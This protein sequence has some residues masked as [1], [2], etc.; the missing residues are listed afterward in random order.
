MNKTSNNAKSANFIRSVFALVGTIIGVG[1]Y[2]IPYASAQSGFFVGLAY[3]IILGLVTLIILRA[4]GEVVVHTPG[5]G[6]LISFLRKYTNPLVSHMGAVALVG[7]WWGA[8]VAYIII[9]GTFLNQIFS[10]F[11]F[12]SQFFY[13]I[14][15]FA[16]ASA[17]VLGGLGFVSKIESVFVCALLAVFI[18]IFIKATPQI[19]S[20]NLFTADY[21]NMLLPYGVILFAFGGLGAIPEMRDILGQNKKLLLRAIMAGVAISAVVY[22]FFSAVVVGIAGDST[23]K[24]A[25]SSLIPSLG[26][27][28]SVAAPILG[29]FTVIT[30]FLMLSINAVDTFVYDYKIRFLPAWLLTIGVPF[31]AFLLG[32]RDFISVIGFT[33]SILGGALGM[34]VLY[35]HERARKILSRLHLGRL[36][37]P[38]FAVSIAAIVLVF[39]VIGEVVYY[40]ISL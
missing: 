29:F 16:I 37:T 14:V 33:G 15:F 5:H 27:L 1:I 32:A 2:G 22:I 13:Q 38:R 10:N 21:S 3:L 20:E 30:S 6:R 31:L 19:A 7:S 39:G 26:Q 11:D 24:D 8:L 28:L 23:S 17:L 4:Y 40:F 35:M 36:S 25:L 34:I 12:G 18:L 9:G